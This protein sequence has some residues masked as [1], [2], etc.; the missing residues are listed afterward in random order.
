MTD[1]GR[2]KIAAN[3]LKEIETIGKKLG[4]PATVINPKAATV[5]TAPTKVNAAGISEPVAG[6]GL[7]QIV[8]YTIGG[9][10]LLGIILMVV[11]RWFYPIFKVDP[12]APGFVIIPGTDT[13]DQFWTKRQD[14]RNI[15]IGTSNVGNEV[16]PQPLSSIVLEGKTS[17]SIT[18][19]VFID[20]NQFTNIPAASNFNRTFFMIAPAP[21][22]DKQ[23]VTDAGV[24]LKVELNRDLNMVQIVCMGNGGLIQTAVIDNV[25]M[26]KPFRIG[27]VKTLYS[28][29]AYL[30]GELVQTIKIKSISDPVAGQSSTLN[31]GTNGAS[32]V[33]APQNILGDTAVPSSTASST[34]LN[35]SKGIQVL[36]LRLFE[37]SISPSEMKARMSDLTDVSEFKP[38]TT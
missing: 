7:L 8:M 19:D 29:A 33:I 2:A 20:E 34:A 37:D 27:I 26:H 23:L 17:Y 18:M 12:G 3:A 1:P 9:I 36:N 31:P 15:R 38:P 11:D 4:K 24:V 21:T 32:Y 10:L 30:N 13:S 6:S 5:P 16:V 25:P 22:G 35:L 14:V 28:I